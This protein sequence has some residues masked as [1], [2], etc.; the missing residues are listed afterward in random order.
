MSFFFEEKPLSGPEKEA[1]KNDI[2]QG[3]YHASEYVCEEEVLELD[4]TEGRYQDM[5]QRLQE[6]QSRSQ[7]EDVEGKAAQEGEDDDQKKGTPS[8]RLIEDLLKFGIEY[9]DHEEQHP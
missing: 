6:L 7:V 8:Y 2:S 1:Y 3:I 9:L 5:P 4:W